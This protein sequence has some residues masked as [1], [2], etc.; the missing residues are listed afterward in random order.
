[1]FAQRVQHAPHLMD[2]NVHT[3]S[4]INMSKES[5][6]RKSSNFGKN[7]HIEK[8]SQL[9]F[10]SCLTGNLFSTKSYVFGSNITVSVLKQFSP[11]ID[12]RVRRM[13]FVAPGSGDLR[14]FSVIMP[15]ITWHKGNIVTAMRVWFNKEKDYME[16]TNGVEMNTYEDSYMYIQTFNSWYEPI[17]SGSLIG[18][19]TPTS[20]MLGVV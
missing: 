13:F 15:A 5:D 10:R 6:Y 19:P 2:G 17:T 3:G 20:T 14:D 1:M 4:A 11:M 7:M 9:P 12:K 8:R 18:I 16:E